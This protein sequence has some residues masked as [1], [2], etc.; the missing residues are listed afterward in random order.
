LL[1]IDTHKFKGFE[2]IQLALPGLS[3]GIDRKETTGRTIFVQAQPIRFSHYF[4]F[5]LSTI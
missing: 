1:Q 2:A 5:Q 4:A 3:R